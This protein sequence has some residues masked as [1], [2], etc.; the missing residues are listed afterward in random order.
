MRG[1]LTV[2]TQARHPGSESASPMATPRDRPGIHHRGR[3]KAVAWTVTVVVLAGAGAGIWLARPFGTHGGAS[4]VSDNAYPVSYATVTRRTLTSQ[5]SVD[6]TLGYA[7]SYSV[8]N[9]ARGIYTALPGAG[10][11]YRDGQVLYRVDGNP[12]MLLY[13]TVPAYRSLAEGQYASSTSGADVEQLNRDLVAMGY[14]SSSAMA[15]QGWSYFG[16]ET[17]YALERLQAGLGVKQTGKLDLGQ[18]VFL[19]SAARITAVQPTLGTQAGPGSQVATASSTAR[20]VSVSL[21]AAQQSQVAPGDRVT[22]TLPNGRTTPGRV[23]SVSKVAVSSSSGP[24]VTV[25][26]TPLDQAAT[27]TL[28]QAPVTV[29]IT[30]ASVPDALVV[31][32]S[33][34]LSL[35][36]GGYA[37][38]EVTPGGRHTLV[39]ASP[40][41]FDDADGLVQ[42]SGPGLAA[43]QRVVVPAT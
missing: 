1:R 17:K 5:A 16:W 23:A 8:V 3:R 32:V 30:T 7:G 21:D 41:L 40:G 2:S 13:G 28:D 31:P 9:Q 6:G 37:V 15:G 36:S 24:T 4:G 14:A 11:V 26:I 38:E 10:Q 33:A 27:G 12:V 34:L 43:G 19:P 42:V 20:Q 18:A 35:A 39:P 29:L 25:L 22:I